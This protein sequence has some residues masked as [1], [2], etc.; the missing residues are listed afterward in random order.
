[1]LFPTPEFAVFF[2]A[3]F[4]AA[5]LLR[6]QAEPRKALLLAASYFFYGY[7]DWHLLGLLAGSSALNYMA[8]VGLASTKSETLRHR[9]VTAAVAVTV[10]VAS[11]AA[12]GNAATRTTTDAMNAKTSCLPLNWISR[13]V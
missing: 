12:A 6:T 13:N 1:M 11:L 7:W 2:F 10:V 9:I 8:G 5:W 4:V 3:I